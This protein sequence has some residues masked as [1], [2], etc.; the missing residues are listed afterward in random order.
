MDTFKERLNQIIPAITSDHFL[1]GRGLGNEIAFYIFD[2]PPEKE[3]EVR[4][5]IEFVLKY[6]NRKRPDL[7]IKHVN[8]FELVIG[9]L[10]ERRLLDKALK[11]QMEKGDRQLLKAI[12][13]PL[14]PAKI[15]RVFVN[16]AEPDNHHMVLVSG[17]GT[18]WPLMRT[19]NLLNNLH[20]L[21]DS[22][23]LVLFY[24]GVFTGYGLQLFG[25]LKE[26]NY[27]R[28]FRLVS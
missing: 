28:A 20:P 18:V 12:K 1:K 19:R 22:T 8:L 5:H 24:P 23:P 25:R 6:L 27:Y 3:L 16:R 9:Y 10:K 13:A 4:K 14:D 2:Y 11:I 15:A 17:A 21:M 7:R 26:S